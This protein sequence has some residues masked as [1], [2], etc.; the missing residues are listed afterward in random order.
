MALSWEMEGFGFS[1]TSNEHCT[2]GKAK[3]S[4]SLSEIA[5]IPHSIQVTTVLP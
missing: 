2:L 3:V 5:K 1:F 4:L